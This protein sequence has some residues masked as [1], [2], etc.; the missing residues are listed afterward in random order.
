MPR[1]G[2]YLNSIAPMTVEELQLVAE[3]A[4]DCFTYHAWN[5]DQVAKGNAVRLAL[6]AAFETVI[7]NVPPSADRSTALRKIRE[8]R[9]YAN[10]AI[11]HNGRY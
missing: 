6:Q 8:A 11:T 5:A 2:Q 1:T 7:A 3:G 10:S 9:M 4:E